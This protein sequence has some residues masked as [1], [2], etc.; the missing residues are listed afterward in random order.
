MSPGEQSRL[1]PVSTTTQDEALRNDVRRFLEAETNLP[2]RRVG[3]GMAA[4]HDSA[5]TE[6]LAER[7]WVGMEIPRK[8][9]GSAYNA[10]QRFVIS[11]ELLAAG[12]PITAHWIADRQIAPSIMRY[13]SPQQRDQFLPPIA[14][15]KCFFSIGM[16]EPEAGS[17]LASVRTTARQV[18]HGWRLNG[19]KIWT[20]LAH[21]NHFVLV[22]ARVH[23]TSVEQR[24]L[25]QLIVDLSSPG[26]E[27]SPI[28]LLTG[29]HHF[30]IMQLDE[31][32][33]PDDMVL[34]APGDGWEQVTNELVLE[35]SGPDRF[36]SVL[37]LLVQFMQFTEQQS[38][39]VSGSLAEDLGRLVA[40]YWSV[41]QMSLA[42]ARLADEGIAS[43]LYGSMAK[44]LGTILEQDTVEA[45][46]RQL[47]VEITS[48]SELP[49]L[50]LLT[51]AV[52]MAPS[53]TIRGG[54]TEILRSIISK[55][56]HES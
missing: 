2:H 51:E 26:L 28:L 17:D 34:G 56:L 42:V 30:N 32:F 9:G 41:R 39:E 44:D 23:G 13:G 36:L 38:A 37:P 40:R 16:S 6:R 12:A 47:R 10:V 21:L 29:E 20:S 55:K 8:Y 15:G 24:S 5:F 22:L 19:A 43:G 3:L 1:S 53:F 25:V 46:R 31:V 33:V 11:E 54:T 49:F 18:D 48:D 35:R 50:Q 4:G 52:L 27:L 45:I 7:G 14:A